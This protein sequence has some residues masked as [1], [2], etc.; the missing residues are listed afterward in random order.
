MLSIMLSV[1]R[2]CEEAFEE[3]EWAPELIISMQEEEVL[4]DF[5]LRTRC[6]MRGAAEHAVVLRALAVKSTFEG[7]ETS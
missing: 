1:N 6:S 3:H 4:V 5:G 2:V 7:E